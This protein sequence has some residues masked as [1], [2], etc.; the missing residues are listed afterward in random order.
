MSFPEAITTCL[1]K[2]ADFK[3]RASRSEFWWFVLL[4]YGVLFLPLII[5]GVTAE[6][7]DV[8]PSIAG[9][10]IGLAFLALVLPYVAAG[11]RRLHDTDKSGWWWFIS[12]I[13]FGS[14]I[15]IVFWA[16][17]GSPGTNQYRPP[18]G[19]ETAALP[20]PSAIPPP[21]PPPPPV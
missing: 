3:G 17:K 2:Y 5:L 8:I 19:A 7:G 16:S 6:S 21:P 12:L 13:P 9:P 15:L 11:V 10:L 20:E 18:P 4:Y 1:R 14:I